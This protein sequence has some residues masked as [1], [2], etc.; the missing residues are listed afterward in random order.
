MLT[1]WGS[2]SYPFCRSHGWCTCSTCSLSAVCY[3]LLYLLNVW[4]HSRGGSQL[5]AWFWLPHW[6]V[7]TFCRECLVAFSKGKAQPGEAF[8][9]GSWSRRERSTSAT[10]PKVWKLLG[11]GSRNITAGFRANERKSFSLHR[12]G[13]NPFL[14]EKFYFSRRFWQ[15]WV[16]AWATGSL[17]RQDIA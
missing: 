13:I 3:S 2:G 17:Q 10:N 11:T 6:V 9:T 8:Q 15:N 1:P 14:Y 12:A 16:A 7:Q 5:L 4:L